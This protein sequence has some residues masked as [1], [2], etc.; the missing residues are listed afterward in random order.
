MNFFTIAELLLSTAA[1]A[2]LGLALVFATQCFIGSLP[3]RHR[4]PPQP[5]RR[6]RLA[7]LIPAH[8]ESAGIA[9]TMQNLLPQLSSGDRLVVIADNCTDDTAAAARQA[10]SQ[11][12]TTAEVLVLE[13]HDPDQRGKG[14]A[15]AFGRKALVADPPDVV[16]LVDADCRV[17]SGT[18][19]DLAAW[20]P[21]R[22]TL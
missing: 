13:R 20:A 16:V 11:T 12:A 10:A 6:P 4:Q 15:L 22:E 5:P 14:Y 21:T 8:N 1:I 18:V 7:V 3:W 17:T 9:A 2:L 19:A